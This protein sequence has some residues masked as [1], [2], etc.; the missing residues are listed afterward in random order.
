[1]EE[2]GFAADERG[3]AAFFQATS[4]TGYSPWPATFSL[5]SGLTSRLL[6]QGG[7]PVN[8]RL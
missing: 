4:Q 5:E 7:K 2:L 6:D 8:A 1:M 3:R